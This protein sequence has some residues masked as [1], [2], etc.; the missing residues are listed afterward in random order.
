ML[1]NANGRIQEGVRHSD[2]PK[3][4]LNSDHR[5]NGCWDFTE[6]WKRVE[7]RTEDIMSRLGA[8]EAPKARKPKSDS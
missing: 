4:D 2:D 6:E 5:E 3:L 7:E 8:L 1:R